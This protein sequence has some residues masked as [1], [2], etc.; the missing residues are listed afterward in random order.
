MMETGTD[1]LLVHVNVCVCVFVRACAY[2]CVRERVRMRMR[3]YSGWVLELNKTRTGRTLGLLPNL[4]ATSICGGGGGVCVRSRVSSAGL[5]HSLSN[6]GNAAPSQ[7][8]QHF[9][10]WPI[11]EGLACSI[12]RNDCEVKLTRRNVDESWGFSLMGS[13][14]KYSPMTGGLHLSMWYIA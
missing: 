3:V 11:P 12:D 10:D 5:A 13:D 1:M 6:Y 2:S 14:D 7:L 8:D 9:F 4:H